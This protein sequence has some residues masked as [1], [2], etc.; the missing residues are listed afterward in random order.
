MR[1][2][3]S[4]HRIL[5]KHHEE[6]KWIGRSLPLDTPCKS[7]P[8]CSHLTALRWLET[9]C[10]DLYQKKND[11]TERKEELWKQREF[12]RK[13]KHACIHLETLH[14]SESIIYNRWA[15][16]LDSEVLDIREKDKKLTKHT[17]K[18]TDVYRQIEADEQQTHPNRSPRGCQCTFFPCIHS[19][20]VM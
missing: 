5:Q 18:L 6:L 15:E 3:R 4:P 1:P 16:E 10:S 8:L 20:V 13:G 7:L 19:I 2:H 17:L 12:L 11:F 14:T 9:L